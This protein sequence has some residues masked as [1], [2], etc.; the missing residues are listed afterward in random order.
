MI[1]AKRIF[2]PSSVKDVVEAPIQYWLERSGWAGR[3]SELTQPPG[4]RAD[5][6][7]TSRLG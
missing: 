4:G 6:R 7:V 2:L 1:W 5:A 3:S